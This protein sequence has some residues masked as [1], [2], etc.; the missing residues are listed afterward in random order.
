MA[1]YPPSDLAESV[2]EAPRDAL[3]GWTAERLVKKQTALG[4]SAFLYFFDHGYPAADAAGLHAFHASEI[5]YVFGTAARTPP[6]WP[7]VPA[8]PPEKHLSEMMTAYWVAFARDGSPDAPG[9]PHWLP[10]GANHAY[11]ALADIPKAGTHLLPG[12]YELHERVVCRRRANG[13]IPWNWNVGIISPP[14]PAE[15]PGCR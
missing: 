3:Y 2:L 8:E 15:V 7:K 13:G 1:V 11:M 4:V 6:L 10:Y 14:L 12:M 9:Q 5:P